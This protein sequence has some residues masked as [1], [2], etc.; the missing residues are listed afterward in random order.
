[1]WCLHS[2]LPSQALSPPPLFKSSCSLCLPFNLPLLMFPSLRRARL[3]LLHGCVIRL[4]WQKK[5]PGANP[6]WGTGAMACC[7]S[8]RVCACVCVLVSVVFIAVQCRRLCDRHVVA[9][10]TITGLMIGRL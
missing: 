3:D 1:M 6:L 9:F 8:D 4:Q 5:A 10:C 7:L 2:L